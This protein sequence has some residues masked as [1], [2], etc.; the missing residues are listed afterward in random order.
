VRSIVCAV[1]LAV[2]VGASADEI[3]TSS[4]GAH[5]VISPELHVRSGPGPQFSILGKLPHQGEVSIIETYQPRDGAAW[6]KIRYGDGTGWVN[7]KYLYWCHY[8]GCAKAS[9]RHISCGCGAR[10]KCRGCE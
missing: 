4:A 10:A 6:A 9:D 2:S 1:M 8:A 7:T 5:Y 3:S